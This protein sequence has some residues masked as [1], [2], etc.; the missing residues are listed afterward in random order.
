LAKSDLTLK[1]ALEIAQS[2]EAAER[3]TQQLKEGDASTF[4]VESVAVSNR[5]E[6]CYCC[7]GTIRPIGSAVS[8]MQNAII[9]VAKG[10][11]PEA[12]AQKELHL[13][14]RHQK[15]LRKGES[16]PEPGG[17]KLTE[18]QTVQK[19]AWRIPWCARSKTV[20][21]EPIQLSCISME[22]H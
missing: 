20:K 22:I 8:S 14:P 12:A 4:S 18:N 9:A 7:G 17:Y 5:K 2:Q 1:W 11:L 19:I 16:G 10:T 6:G 15:S 13:R 3:N 21:L